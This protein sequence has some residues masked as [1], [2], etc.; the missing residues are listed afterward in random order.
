MSAHLS[1]E[2]IRSFQKNGFCSPIRVYSEVETAELRRQFEAVETYFGPERAKRHITD[3]HLIADWAWRVVHDPRIVEPISDVLGPNVLLWSL[4]WFIKEPLDQK[5]VSYH[6][7][8][9]YWG[10]EPHDVATAWIALSDASEATG[11]MKFVSGSHLE[12]VRYHEDTF[13]KDNLLSRGQVIEGDIDEEKVVLSPL[14]AGEMSLH[15]VRLIH[16]STPNQTTDRRIGMVLRYCA[17]HVRQT[18]VR[19]TAVL[20]RGEDRFGNFDLLPKPEKEFG[21]VE[22]ARQRDALVRMQRALHSKDYE[23]Q[24]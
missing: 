7:D 14:G 8:A 12:E 5:F 17:T 10:L 23:D 2:A 20:V 18:K 1:A 13:G 11:P 4:N 24:D 21:E 15:H 3:L 9:T 22:L 16:G 6:Q 19:D